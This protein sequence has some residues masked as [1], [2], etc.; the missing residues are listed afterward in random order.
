MAD[1]GRCLAAR[2]FMLRTAP[3]FTVAALRVSIAIAGV[4]DVH[5]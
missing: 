5:N 4:P 1:F 3:C 2:A